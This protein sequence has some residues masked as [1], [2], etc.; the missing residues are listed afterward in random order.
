MSEQLEFICTQCPL[1]NCDEES[2]WCLFRFLTDPNNAQRQIAPEGITLRQYYTRKQNVKPE[3]LTR[4][5]YFR[6]RYINK[7]LEREQQKGTQQC[8]MR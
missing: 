6:Q 1:A 2:L 5:A 7:K 3:T 8:T 4:R